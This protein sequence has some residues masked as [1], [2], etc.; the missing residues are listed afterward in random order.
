[1]TVAVDVAELDLATDGV[2]KVFNLTGEDGAMALMSPSDLRV[3]FVDADGVAT[4][5]TYTID[6]SIA[7]DYRNGAG[8]LT[9]LAVAAYEDGGRLAIRRNTPRT[10]PEA[11]ADNDGFAAATMQNAQDRGRLIDQDT[12]MRDK[13]ALT[14]P[15]YEDWAGVLPNKSARLGKVLSFDPVTGEPTVE[16]PL[17]QQAQDAADDAIGAAAALAAAVNQ[18]Y[19]FAKAKSSGDFTSLEEATVPAIVLFVR[20]VGYS[21]IGKGAATY[22]RVDDAPAHG[23]YIQSTDGAYWELVADV[24]DPRMVGAACDGATDD[25]AALEIARDYCVATGAVFH[26]PAKTIYFTGILTFASAISVIG[27]GSDVSCFK[28]DGTGGTIEFAAANTTFKGFRVDCNRPGAASRTA[29]STLQA[30]IGVHGPMTGAPGYISNVFV[31]DIFVTNS[32]YQT[33]FVA[34]NC[35]D[36]YF[37]RIRVKDSWGQAVQFI[38]LKDSRVH[39]VWTRNTGNLLVLGTRAGQGLAIF[40]ETNAGKAPATWYVTGGEQVT[41]N[42]DFD[43]VDVAQSTDSAVYVHD[44]NPLIG[45]NEIRFGQIKVDT[46]GK[47]GVKVISY[48]TKVIIQSITATR[49]AQQ[50]VALNTS[51]GQVQIGMALIRQCGYDAV[52]DILGVASPWTTAANGLGQSLQ[53]Q[54]GGCFISGTADKIS[55]GWLD[56]DTVSRNPDDNTYGYGL[57]AVDSTRVYVRGILRNADRY[58]LRLSNVTKASKFDVSVIDACRAALDPAFILSDNATGAYSSDCEIIFDAIETSGAAVADQAIRVNGGSNVTVSPRQVNPAHFAHATFGVV[59]KI[60]S[61]LTGFIMTRAIAFVE[62][63]GTATSDAADGHMTEA[64]G[65]YAAPTGFVQLINSNNYRM[66][67]KPF[68]ATNANLVLLKADGTSQNSTSATWFK[69]YRVQTSAGY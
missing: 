24:C 3:W 18:A 59:A 39:L 23:A 33:G 55:I 58:G 27:L 67:V 7:G 63:V 14:A 57:Y 46:A 12:A 32:N 5:L 26:V 37:G 42:V 29:A 50:G 44:Y 69:H 66:Q 2:T 56:V 43:I 16:D 1:M 21:Q 22:K 34:V 64:H 30:G 31:D 61:G 20:T 11:W 40:A 45:S 17:V 51:I 13:R 8:T 25:I 38:G 47:D 36:S 60:A 4:E 54:P 28:L 15:L 10:Q 41:T 6:F 62:G 52:G 49:V 9:T 65:L 19:S 35:K 53:Q 48:A 68:D